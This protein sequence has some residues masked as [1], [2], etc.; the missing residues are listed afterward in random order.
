MR[1]VREACDIP[2]RARKTRDV[3]VPDRVAADC[4]HDRDARRRF[5]GRADRRGVT[6]HDDGDRKA[7]E[8]HCKTGEE[9]GLV[10]REPVFDTKVFTFHVAECPKPFQEGFVT[11]AVG[12]L[13]PNAK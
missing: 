4:H 13:R 2:T 7:H 12:P 8:L 5:L 9:I 10:V 1:Y 6:R 11:V 3:S